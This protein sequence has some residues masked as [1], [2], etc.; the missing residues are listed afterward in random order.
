M[1]RSRTRR[2]G[3]F[4][5]WGVTSQKKRTI[6]LGPFRFETVIAIQIECLKAKL[7][8]SFTRVTKKSQYH[9]GLSDEEKE[10]FSWYRTRIKCKFMQMDP[11]KRDFHSDMRFQKYLIRLKK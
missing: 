5:E 6:T 2:I 9:L 7:W 11:S 3:A 10:T 8:C 4:F 1:R